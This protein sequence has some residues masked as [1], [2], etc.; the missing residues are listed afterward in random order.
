MDGNRRFGEHQGVEKLY[1][2]KYGWTKMRRAGLFLSKYLNIYGR[3][4][5]V[6]VA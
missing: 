5:G 6:D 2:H 3:I 4:A 1:G